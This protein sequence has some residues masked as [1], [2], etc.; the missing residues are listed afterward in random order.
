[1]SQNQ[2]HITTKDIEQ[3]LVREQQIVWAY[4]LPWISMILI[5]VLF[6]HSWLRPFSTG[7][8]YMIITLVLIPGAAI[9]LG[10]WIYNKLRRSA[11]AAAANI[12][13]HRR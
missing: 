7:I 6:A 12:N 9:A 8:L 2:G 11:T 4:T 5:A 10:A 3:Q 1:M 13:K